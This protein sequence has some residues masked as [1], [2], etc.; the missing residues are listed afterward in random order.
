VFVLDVYI[1]S[2]TNSSVQYLA[3]QGKADLNLAN[4]EGRTGMHLAAEKGCLMVRDI[5]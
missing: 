1:F 4:N 3:E 5:P 2:P